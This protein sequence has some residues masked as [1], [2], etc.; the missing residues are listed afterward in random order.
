M[1]HR[2]CVGVVSMVLM[3]A[4]EPAFAGCDSSDYHSF[5]DSP[6][7]DFA[8]LAFDSVPSDAALL[9][10]PL[11]VPIEAVQQV[12]ED[13]SLGAR[14]VGKRKTLDITT[15]NSWRPD[16]PLIDGATYRVVFLDVEIS[17]GY[18]S[19]GSDRVVDF[20]VDDSVAQETPDSEIVSAHSTGGR[21]FEGMA[22]SVSPWDGDNWLHEVQVASDSVFEEPLSSLLTYDSGESQYDSFWVR[23]RTW[24]PSGEPGEWSEPVRAC[25]CAEAS[26][27][28][29]PAGLLAVLSLAAFRRGRP[30]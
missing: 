27:K 5:D 28:P 14:V 12:L 30:R 2:S 10:D 11:D 22:V 29:A 17:S 9:T 26:G 3:A 19:A 24:G 18:P 4:S 25:G 6:W 13:G 16:A 8:P 15:F 7:F 1:P 20:V 21:C 23:T